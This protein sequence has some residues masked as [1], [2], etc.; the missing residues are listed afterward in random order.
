VS[1]RQRSSG[2]FTVDS[3]TFSVELAE[4]SVE[5]REVFEAAVEGDCRDIAV[6][7]CQLEGGSFN[8]QFVD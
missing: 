3:R 2:V 8:A 1:H 6:G 4:S 5:V 7:C